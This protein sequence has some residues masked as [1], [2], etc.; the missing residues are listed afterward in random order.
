MYQWADNT[1]VFYT[2]DDG[3]L[4][5][6]YSAWNHGEPNNH[7]GVEDCI[8]VNLEL[9]LWNDLICDDERELNAFVCEIGESYTHFV[10]PPIYCFIVLRFHET[11]CSRVL[12]CALLCARVIV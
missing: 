3:T 2:D 12:D 11:L 5:S 6:M 10:R 8:E 9:G 7:D 4:P 1:G